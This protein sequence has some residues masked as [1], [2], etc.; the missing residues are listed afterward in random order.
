MLEIRHRPGTLFKMRIGIHSGQVVAGIVGIKMPHYCLFGDAVNIASRM[1][2]TSEPL[3]IQISCSTFEILNKTN[4][5]ICKE[6]AF[7]YIKGKGKM[8]TFWLQGQNSKPQDCINTL[9][10]FDDKKEHLRKSMN[11]I[12]KLLIRSHSKSVR[13]K[14]YT[15]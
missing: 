7:T 15:L 2:S 5:F 13:M 3:K 10:A 9:I 4:H 1:E 8:K 6:R 12:D 11:N 14:A